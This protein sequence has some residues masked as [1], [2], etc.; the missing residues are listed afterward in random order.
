M[1]WPSP[2][3]LHSSPA[4]N[5]TLKSPLTAAANAVDLSSFS[6]FLRRQ[7]PEL[8]PSGG[9]ALADVSVGES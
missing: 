9:R 5:P 1:T 8:L 3:R 4:L 7:A 2:D 6:E